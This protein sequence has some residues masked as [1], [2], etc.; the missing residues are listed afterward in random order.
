LGPVPVRSPRSFRAHFD[1]FFLTSHPKSVR[2]AIE[3]YRAGLD[4]NPMAFL[5]EQG[6]ETDDRIH[7]AA[8]EYC[9]V[10]GKR[11]IALT[12]STT[13]GLAVL[14]SGLTVRPDQ[15][16]LTSTHDHP[17]ATVAALRFRQ[18][19]SGT[20]VVTVPLYADSAKATA[21]E[22]VDNVAKNVGPRTRVLALTWVHSCTGVKI[23]VKAI[24][25]VVAQ[26]NKGRDAKDRLVFCLDGV[27]GF[28]IE[29]A[30]LPALGCDFFS[31]GTH[32]WMFGPRGT[33]ILWGREELWEHVVPMVPAFSRRRTTV[34]AQRFSPGG[35]HSFEHRWALEEAFRFHLAIGKP[36]VHAR[37]HA[38][39]RAL[40]EGLAKM[41]HVDLHTPLADELACGITCFDVKG[42]TPD[43]VVSRLAD[44]KIAGS[45]SPYDPSCARLA[46]SLWNDEDQVAAALK[47]V[48]EITA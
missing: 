1:G 35:F 47:A 25:E 18:Q 3:K 33:G 2:A 34:P 16:I 28:G 46:A 5:H 44:K 36:R 22:I 8:G 14:Y 30:T 19:R 48:G 39:N 43:Q 13:M 26:A 23:P 32:K 24:A 9:G 15:E 45:V 31:A 20:K 41:R 17:A 4:K 11:E 38:L 29:D 12:G 37:I 42:M 21:D 10:D 6:G 27:H 7:E 40:R